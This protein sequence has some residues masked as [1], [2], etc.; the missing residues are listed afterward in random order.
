MADGHEK[1]GFGLF[2]AKTKLLA[3]ALGISMLTPQ[4]ASAHGD[5]G[6]PRYVS[7]SGEDAGDC[8]LPVRPCRTIGY[9]MSVLGKG[10]EIR[11][12]AGRYELRD[13]ET[14]FNLTSGITDAS[15]GFSRFDHF[16][17][18]SPENN[19][20]TLIGV[21]F[22]YRDALTARGFQV[23]SDLKTVDRAQTR[24]LAELHHTFDAINQSRGPQGC[25]N[26][27]AGVH[28]CEKIDLL[29][30]LALADFESVPPFMSDIWGFV[31]LNTERE[32]ALVGLL[33]GVSIVDVTNPEAPFEV[34]FVFGTNIIWRDLKVLQTYD[35]E[36]HRWNAYAY[37][38]GEDSAHLLVIDL[39][40]LPNRVSLG[41]RLL[42]T[43]IHNV[44]MSNVDYATG[45]QTTGAPPL[46][47]ALGAWR[48]GGRF[49]SYD[50]ADPL[51]P[52]LV[53][54]S[55]SGYS[56]DATSLAVTDHRA[57]GCTAAEESCEVLVD[58]NED[59]VDFWDFSDQAAPKML[60]SVSYSG[61][62][63]VHSGWWSEDGRY[64]FVQDELDERQFG[65]R[66]TL[67]VI[68]LADLKSPVHIATWTGPTRAIDHNGFVR[69]NRYYMSNYTRGVTVLDI[70]D[71][72]KP[73][74]IGLFDTYPVSDSTAFAAAWGVYPFLPSGTLLVSDSD[75]GLYLLEDRTRESR[76]GKL[77]F[78]TPHYGGHEGETIDIAVQRLSGSEGAVKA[79][80]Q[81]YGASADAAD[82]I[83][84]RGTLSWAAGDSGVRS[85]RVPLSQ[86]SEAEPI[87]RAMVKITNPTGGAVLGDVN[88]ASLFIADSGGTT[89]LTFADKRILVEEESGR[90]IVTVKR[91]GSP[92]GRVL[93]SVEVISGTALAGSDY[94][95][96]TERQLRWAHGDATARTLVIDLIADDVEEK[97]ETFTVRLQSATGASVV[98]GEDQVQVEIGDDSASAVTDIM[99]YDNIIQRD[100]RVMRDGIRL[101][102]ESVQASRLN[103]RV[104]L[105][106]ANAPG[107]VR[108]E[109]SGPVSEARSLPAG[110]RGLL[111]SGATQGATSLPVG[112]YQLTATPYAEA[113]LGGAEGS[114]ASVSFLVGDPTLEI[115]NS[116]NGDARLRSLSLGEI[117][118]QFDPEVEDYSL[119][120]DRWFPFVT[121]AAE[122]WDSTATLKITP[123]D[124][125]GL[126]EGHQVFLDPGTNV[127]EVTVTA[128]DGVTSRTYRL[129]ILRR[130]AFRVF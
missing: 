3:L 11:V 101:R 14:I 37:V 43:G 99:L 98:E 108:F 125:L 10:G 13:T 55:T 126:L 56:H 46:L 72:T 6:A 104:Q 84:T 71:P 122:P 75:T 50:L 70:T 91:I 29:S 57:S 78:S 76:A 21:P 23:V 20:T 12:A 52:V 93:G 26:N 83:L 54:E 65:L 44:Y 105:R 27:R 106:D 127:I 31:D 109:L 61:A 17:N 121:L 48:S 33:N 18:A 96:P 92:V 116:S 119:E 47:Q 86:D 39:T 97:A 30:H 58:F 1:R 95:E 59:T 114:A 89:G 24:Q 60:S 77:S 25:V 35:A 90:A 16:L 118:F 120:Y 22:A 64:V 79:D 82:L 128:E 85:I 80:Y 40:E 38:S 8:T 112:S 111:F 45:V 19:T 74:D 129:Q 51:H 130:V 63:Y 34:G 68:G 9:A 123:E 117:S 81:V 107:S 7:E 62:S 4:F 49:L 110:D 88:V 102:G 15:G 41:H 124:G 53:A 32:Y 42:D 103:F 100:T 73:K 94:V 66:T 69:G 115:E 36:Q 67:R 5:E 87:E 113:D 2:W 28:A